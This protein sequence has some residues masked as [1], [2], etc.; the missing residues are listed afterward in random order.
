MDDFPKDRGIYVYKYIIYIYMEFLKL[1]PCETCFASNK[2]WRSSFR[3]KAPECQQNYTLQGVF[4]NMR[5]LLGSPVF[6][7]INIGG[8]PFLNDSF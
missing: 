2:K 4:L 6:Q 8:T 7:S 5:F 3:N 1:P